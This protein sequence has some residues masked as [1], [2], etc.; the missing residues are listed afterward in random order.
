MQYHYAY[1]WPRIVSLKLKLLNVAPSDPVCACNVADYELC[2]KDDYSVPRVADGRDKKREH[3]QGVRYEK[4]HLFALLYVTDNKC[5]EIKGG[6][7]NHHPDNGIAETVAK[8]SHFTGLDGYCRPKLF[9][10]R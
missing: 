4:R 7:G 3:E 9:M 5:Q 6:E 8:D 10:L 2:W 1:L